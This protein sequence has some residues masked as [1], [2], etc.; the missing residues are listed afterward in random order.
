[1]HY[2]YVY[3]VHVCSNCSEYTF[4]HILNVRKRIEVGICLPAIHLAIYLLRRE[5]AIDGFLDRNTIFEKE[6]SVVCTIVCHNSLGTVAMLGLTVALKYWQVT[7]LAFSAAYKRFSEVSCS[8]DL[9][10]Y[11]YM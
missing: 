3:A 11:M 6:V 10:K 9:C 5:Y 7:L 2:A 8:P 4:G 1:M